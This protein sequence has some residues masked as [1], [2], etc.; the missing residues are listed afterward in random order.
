MCLTYHLTFP[1]P[2]LGLGINA[3]FEG[4]RHMINLLDKYKRSDGSYDFEKV[5]LLALLLPLLSVLLVLLLPEIV[6]CLVF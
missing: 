6:F 1:V 2:F 5:R 4:V 3:G